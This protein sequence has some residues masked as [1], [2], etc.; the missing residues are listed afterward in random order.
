MDASKP[1]PNDYQVGGDHY[2]KHSPDY[3]HWDLVA[4]FHMNYF[5]AN[6]TKYVVRW[7]EKE[8]VKDLQKTV[9][10]CEKLMSLYK[11]HRGGYHWGL[12]TSILLDKRFYD[13]C[14]A[15]PDMTQHEQQIIELAVRYACPEDLELLHTWLVNLVALAMQHRAATGQPSSTGSPAASQPSS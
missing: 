5:T 1:A 11:E 14:A 9:H 12:R 8:G 15:Q 2:R 6:I 4:D 10:Y 3:Q 13:W 7:R